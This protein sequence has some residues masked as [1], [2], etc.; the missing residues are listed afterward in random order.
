[1][2]QP[3]IGCLEHNSDKKNVDKATVL[4]LLLGLYP[5]N[6]GYLTVI[7]HTGTCLTSTFI[8]EWGD[9]DPTCMRVERLILECGFLEKIR[10]SCL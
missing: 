1:M 8:L 7:L 6:I 5:Q 10:P 4:W 9:N 2:Q 3:R